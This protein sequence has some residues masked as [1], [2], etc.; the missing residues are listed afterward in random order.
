MTSIPILS[1]EQ[2]R[3]CNRQ[4]SDLIDTWNFSSSGGLAEQQAIEQLLNDGAPYDYR[5]DLDK[6]AQDYT[7]QY[8]KESYLIND[9]LTSSI[10]FLSRIGTYDGIAHFFRLN[11]QFHFSANQFADAVPNIIRAVVPHKQ[12]NALE[13]LQII[14]TIFV[15]IKELDPD[16][17]FIADSHLMMSTA[18]Y[19]RHALPIVDFLFQQGFHFND[20]CFYNLFIKNHGEKIDSLIHVWN[21]LLD[22]P[23][24]E[25]VYG[26][27]QT[28]KHTIFGI[29]AKGFK[30]LPDFNNCPSADFILNHSFSQWQTFSSKKE[31]ADNYIELAKMTHDY[32]YNQVLMIHC[33]IQAGYLVEDCSEIKELS[34]QWHIQSK[35]LERIFLKKH[36]DNTLADYD[37]GDNSESYSVKPPK[38]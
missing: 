8:K 37:T 5:E 24:N 26:S 12:I 22:N 20:T 21:L 13:A 31:K 27:P 17:D 33:L 29:L 36:L 38:I 30:E 6:Q 25:S 14:Q 18:V 11:E 9:A 2:Q 15:K 1:L 32:P 4:L 19:N 7:E 28:F 16:F 23:L 35:Y 3:N 34:T 10:D